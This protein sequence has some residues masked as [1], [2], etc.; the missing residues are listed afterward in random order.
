MGTSMGTSAA[1][2]GLAVVLTTAG[3]NS[4]LITG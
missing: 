2:S 4:D 1:R 3:S